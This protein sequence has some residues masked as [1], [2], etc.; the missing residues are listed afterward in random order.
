MYNTNDANIPTITNNDI[1]RPGEKV[2]IQMSNQN[3]DFNGVIHKHTFIEL[4]Y[5]ISGSATHV[6]GDREFQASKGDLFIINHNTPHAFFS[7]DNN[8]EPFVAYDLLFTP[9]FF[10]ISLIND[11]S[12]ESINSSFLFYSLFPAQQSEPDVHISGSSYSVFGELFNK[13][14]LEFTNCET[15]YI[16]IIRAYVIELIINIFRKM[17]STSNTNR[18]S[19]QS[20]IVETTLKYLK[21]N[22][23]KH[24]SLNDLAAQV[25]LSKDY[26]ARIFRETTGMPISTLLQKI[27]VD[28]ACKLLVNTNQKIDDIAALCGFSDTKYFYNLFKRQTG[29]TPKQYRI[30]HLKN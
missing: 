11:V 19:R 3:A 27:R 8:S 29:L 18:N 14:H 7:N 17:N 13:I 5:I 4:V 15:G 24:L 16:N 1:F 6:V 21:E 30:T 2:F 22:Y 28:E 20:E 9:D 25:F 12:F 10:D 23:H 26:F